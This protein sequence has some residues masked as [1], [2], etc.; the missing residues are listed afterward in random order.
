MT[1]ALAALGLGLAL[2]GAPGPVQVILFAETTRGGIARGMQVVLGANLTFAV[3][4]TALA[5]GL[6]VVAPTGVALRILKLTGAAFLIWIAWDNFRTIRRASPTALD[7]PHRTLPPSLRGVMAVIF[8]PGGWIF[9]ATVASSLLSTA[10]HDSGRAVALVVAA[11][12]VLGILAGDA[13][14]VLLAGF[15]IRRLGER[16][17]FW[18]Q[19]ALNLILV[20]VALWLLAT[21]VSG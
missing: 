21:A 20:A 17:S 3:L 13:A 9:L 12:L 7:Q 5:L 19:A 15:G 2:A 6:S 14:V 1:Q 4:L 18:I 11:L 16:P 8:N 10:V